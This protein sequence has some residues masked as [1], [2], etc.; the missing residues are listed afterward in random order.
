VA[1]VAVHCCRHESVARSALCCY[2]CWGGVGWMITW[3][4]QC[5]AMHLALRCW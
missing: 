2:A 5:E 3:Q 4:P 1:V